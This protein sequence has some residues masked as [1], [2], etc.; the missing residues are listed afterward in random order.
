MKIRTKKAILLPE[1]LKI[2]IAVLSLVILIYLAV[3]LHGIFIQKSRIEQ[4]KVNIDEIIIKLNDLKESESTKY[5]LLSPAGNVLTG[6][7]YKP[8]FGDA[9]YPN[10][11][12]SNR[13]ENCICICPIGES[14]GEQILKGTFTAD[15]IL[16]SC[17]AEG[18]CREVKGTNLIVSEKEGIEKYPIR[19]DYLK[20]EGKPLKISL[21]GGVYEIRP[22]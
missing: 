5:T 15:N 18:I 12:G 17:N 16:E 4:A 19:V 9:L 22:E 2:I 1:V 13:W 21:K 11:C 7:P 6:W 14:L 3:S 10:I 20:N 8:F